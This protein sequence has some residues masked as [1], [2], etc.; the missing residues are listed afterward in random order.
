M[1]PLR[2]RR[3]LREAGYA[4]ELFPED[5][6]DERRTEARHY[7]ELERQPVVRA[8]AGPAKRWL[9]YHS[10]TGSPIVDWLCRQQ[11]PLMVDYHNITEAKYFDRW[12]PVAADNMRKARAELTQLAPYTSFAL[13]DSPFNEAELV[14]VGYG[15]TAVAPILID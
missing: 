15:L 13:A 6:H 1:H 7:R 14:R 4:S 3:G 11:Y 12:A 8:G 10:S 9:L 5:T 2:L